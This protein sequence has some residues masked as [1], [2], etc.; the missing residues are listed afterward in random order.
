MKKIEKEYV[1]SY[2]CRH[3]CFAVFFGFL[4]MLF[5]ASLS[6]NVILLIKLSLMFR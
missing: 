6:L 1:E 2:D 3:G 4:A 5:L